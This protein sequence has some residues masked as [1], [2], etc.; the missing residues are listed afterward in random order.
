M[1]WGKPHTMVS[2]VDTHLQG[3]QSLSSLSLSVSPRWEL[4][5][6]V[7]TGVDVEMGTEAETEAEAEEM[8]VDTGAGMEAEEMEV[9]KMGVEAVAAGKTEMVAVGETGVETGAEL[10]TEVGEPSRAEREVEE[11]SG[12][13]G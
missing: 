4:P 9:V 1:P 5:G 7:W 3:G 6:Q 12:G 8:E 10:G 13:G 11:E 2:P